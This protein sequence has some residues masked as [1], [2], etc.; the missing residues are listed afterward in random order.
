MEERVYF[1]ERGPWLNWGIWTAE[2]YLEK[3]RRQRAKKK[4]S[5]REIVWGSSLLTLF[6]VILWVV[7]AL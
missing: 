1:Y 4:E 7:L 3:K 5:R 2:I 6:I